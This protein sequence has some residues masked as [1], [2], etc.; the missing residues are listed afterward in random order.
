MRVVRASRWRSDQVAFPGCWGSDAISG[1]LRPL[2][3]PGRYSGLRRFLL[4]FRYFTSDSR[5]QHS[6]LRLQALEMLEPGGLR[7]ATKPR[8]HAPFALGTI[9]P[10][11]DF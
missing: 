9:D 7:E 8:L 6:P 10:D 3:G 1:T 4:Y 11:D 2:S 5:C